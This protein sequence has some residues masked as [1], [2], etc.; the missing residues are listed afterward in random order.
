MLVPAGLIKQAVQRCSLCSV[1]GGGYIFTILTCILNK[2][3]TEKNKESINNEHNTQN[4][5]VQ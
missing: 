2:Y 1:I 4:L 3:W 5:G